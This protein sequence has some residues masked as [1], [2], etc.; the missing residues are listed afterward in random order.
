M[1]PWPFIV[2]YSICE[3]DGQSGRQVIPMLISQRNRL[4]ILA[5]YLCR[6]FAYH[7]VALTTVSA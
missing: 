1:T 7:R 3:Q 5:T 2:C 4:F 6:S